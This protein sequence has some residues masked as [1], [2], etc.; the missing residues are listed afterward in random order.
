MLAPYV[1][2]ET[3]TAFERFLAMLALLQVQGLLA[4]GIG[5]ACWGGLDLKQEAHEASCL[6]GR[7][8]R[9]TEFR[10]RY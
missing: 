4:F 10:T 3:L 6:L 2:R 1:Y 8:R 5:A 9:D 7:L